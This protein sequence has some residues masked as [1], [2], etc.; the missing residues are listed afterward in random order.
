MRKEQALV[1]ARLA[2]QTRSSPADLLMLA[3]ECSQNGRL[4]SLDHL[5]KDDV[6]DLIATLRNFLAHGEIF[7]E[8][9]LRP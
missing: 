2:E 1:I 5:G 3:R 9:M 8:W 7:F 4:V 6:D